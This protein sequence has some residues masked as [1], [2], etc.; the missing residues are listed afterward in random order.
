MPALHRTIAASATT[1]ILLLG[2][3]ACGGGSK[4]ADQ[5]TN[6]APTP[7]ETA[8]KPSPKSLKWGEPAEVT[9]HN[10]KKLRVTPVG[11]L[12]SKGPYK[13]GDGPEN[14]WFIALAIK[15]EAVQEPDSTAGGAGGGGF[16][17]RGA[18]QT[19]T[20]MD[21]NSTAPWAGAANGFGV[22]EPLQPGSP[23]V[24]IVT[25]D[26]PA[27]G[28]RLLYVDPGDHSIT[29]WTLPTVDQGTG[30]DKVRKRI[31]MFT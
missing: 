16:Q 25:L 9:G 14:G 26:I 2:L 23:E 30:L 22:D 13:D 5:P 10:F 6:A 28:G 7:G 17:W 3:A 15:A 18:S 19:I 24:G 11:L 31:K 12:Y 8:Q 4:H 20:E 27:K 1:A 21:G 29:S